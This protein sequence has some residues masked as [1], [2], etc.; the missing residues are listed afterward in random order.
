ME[1]TAPKNMEKYYTYREK[2]TRLDEAIAQE[3]YLEAVFIAYAII[4]DR[5]RSTLEHMGMWTELL[6]NKN[7]VPI[8]IKLKAIKK[9]AKKPNAPCASY[10]Q[11]RIPAHPNNT[12]FSFCQ[13]W[14]RDRNQ[15]I[16][17]LMNN[18]LSDV[19]IKELS[20]EGKELARA[21]ADCAGATKRALKKAQSSADKT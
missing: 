5:T 18:P 13:K 2:F 8:S 4:E 21:F 17:D 11:K 15:A 10:L 14:I 16:H 7:D 12:L 3:Y 1:N 6:G 20:Q 19:R 9:E